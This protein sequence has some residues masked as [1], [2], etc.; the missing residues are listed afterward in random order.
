MDEFK[1]ITQNLDNTHYFDNPEWYSEIF[2]VN[3]DIITKDGFGIIIEYRYFAGKFKIGH[4]RGGIRFDNKIKNLEEYKSFLEYLKKELKKHK[5]IFIGIDFMDKESQYTKLFK[6]TNIREF[7]PQTAVIYPKTDWT[8]KFNSKKRYD[9]LYASKKG[10][11]VEFYESNVS[12]SLVEKLYQMLEYTFARHQSVYKIVDKKAFFTIFQKSE[13][14]LGIAF[15]DQ[16]REV[17]IAYNLLLPNLRKNRYDRLFASVNQEGM[18]LRAAPYLEVKTIGRLNEKKVEIYDLWGLWQN[19][20]FS[21]FKKSIAD[22]II[23]LVPYYAIL[24]IRPTLAFIIEN[25]VK[26][27]TFIKK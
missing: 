15:A 20:G 12:I 13:F 2:K 21:E 7:M 26:L 24:R 16:Q 1:K 18:K 22:E 27:G 19:E 8:N 9:M 11:E 6:P 5:Y 3:H 17:P 10:V 23:Q 25:L 14:L 4:S